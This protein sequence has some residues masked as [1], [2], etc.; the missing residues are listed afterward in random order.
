MGRTD[1][2]V[3][4]QCGHLSEFEDDISVAVVLVAFDF[5]LENNVLMVKGSIIG[6][7]VL[8]ISEIRLN[9]IDIHI[10]HSQFSVILLKGNVRILSRSDKST[11]PIVPCF[12]HELSK[13]ACSSFVEADVAGISIV[14]ATSAAFTV[15][16]LDQANQ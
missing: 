9:N 14:P 10:K 16:N 12:F 8:T 5:M 4:T 6:E 7:T 2:L 1:D 11:L 15:S 13:Y 3:T